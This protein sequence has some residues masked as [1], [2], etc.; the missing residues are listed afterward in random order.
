MSPQDSLFQEPGASK[1][2][3]A[4]PFSSADPQNADV[5][6]QLKTAQRQL[7][8]VLLLLLVVSGTFSIYMF[9]EVRYDRADLGNL[10]PQVRQLQQAQQV[11]A[12]YNQVTVPAMTNFLNQL[13]VYAKAHPDVMP[14]LVKH[15]LA[16]PSAPPAASAQR[17]TAP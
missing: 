4:S 3:P 6:S 17:Q 7:S 1:A 10:Q 12:N 16:Q 9:Q 15:G 5:T 11:I 8:N 2:P 13:G 14:I